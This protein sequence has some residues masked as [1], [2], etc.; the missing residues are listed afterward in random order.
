M[1]RVEVEVAVREDKTSSTNFANSI[2]GRIQEKLSGIKGPAGS[3]TRGL[4]SG[5]TLGGIGGDTSGTSGTAGKTIGTLA[6]IAGTLGIV[7]AGISKITGYLSEVSPAMAG[8]LK[9]IKLIFMIFFLPLTPLFLT[10]MKFLANYLSKVAQAVEGQMKSP[11]FGEGNMAEI[12]LN[13]LT[14]VLKGLLDLL[15]AGIKAFVVGFVK[16]IA[17]ITETV[18]NV[19]GKA[20]GGFLMIGAVI[21]AVLGVIALAV[22]GW[23]G[24][25]IAIVGVI[26]AGIIALVNKY[27]S[28]IGTFFVNIWNFIVNVFTTVTGFIANIFKGIAD[29]FNWIFTSI[30]NLFSSVINALSNVISGIIDWISNLGKN[31]IKLATG[32]KVGD[33]IITP[34]GEIIQTDPA[35]YLIATKN[36]QSMG[37]GQTV[38]TINNP[39]FKDRKDMDL[40]IRELERRM[41]TNLRRHTSYVGGIT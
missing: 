22:G 40:L 41:Q 3:F 7:S 12:M 20:R 4:V 33:A 10:V 15:W 8:V 1:P 5:A 32:K 27:W 11:S 39:Q 9:I 37:G 28:A 16:G 29:F 30:V 19:L 26:V 24:V 17:D 38:I 14:T 34:K 31:L 6:L 18:M 36:P 21:V 13:V 35:D 2:V 25:I 23:V